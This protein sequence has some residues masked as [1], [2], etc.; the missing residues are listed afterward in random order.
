MHIIFRRSLNEK[1]A[2]FPAPFTRL[3]LTR[4][5]PYLAAGAAST[6]AG[7]SAFLA[8]LR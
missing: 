8:C 2:D 3:N 6:G 7:A 5:K 1:G 4:I